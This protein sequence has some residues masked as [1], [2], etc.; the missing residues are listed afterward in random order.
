[1]SSSALSSHRHHP[2]SWPSSRSG[3]RVSSSANPGVPCGRTASLRATSGRLEHVRDVNRAHGACGWL[4]PPLTRSVSCDRGPPSASSDSSVGSRR[5]AEGPHATPS[6]DDCAGPLAPS[7]S[8]ENVRDV[9]SA[10]SARHEVG[11]SRR[12][13]VTRERRWLVEE[14][15]GWAVRRARREPPGGV[16]ERPPVLAT[17]ASGQ[18]KHHPV[19]PGASTVRGAIWDR[20]GGAWRLTEYVLLTGERL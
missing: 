20:L 11:T 16:R 8:G 15:N 9:L 6:S 4:Y 17:A 18:A 13:V 5:A 19:Y 2:C 1:M 12:A 14:W 7:A 3:R 10:T